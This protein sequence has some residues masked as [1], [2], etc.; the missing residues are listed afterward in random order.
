MAGAGNRNK[1]STTRCLKPRITCFILWTIS[2]HREMPSEGANRKRRSPGS[3]PS[4]QYIHV[5]PECQRVQ[6]KCSFYGR[7]CNN[8]MPFI[9]MYLWHFLRERRFIFVAH[10]FIPRQ[11]RPADFMGIFC[12]LPSALFLHIIICWAGRSAPGPTA[13]V[14]NCKTT[15]KGPEIMKIRK[16]TNKCNHVHILLSRRNLSLE[17]LTNL[18]QT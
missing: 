14:I 4:P 18:K 15:F 16:K 13:G 3:G 7:S 17:A 10:L 6:D 11:R 1:I 8:V 12:L 2:I 5:P 9:L